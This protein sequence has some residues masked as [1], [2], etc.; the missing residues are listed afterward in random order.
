LDLADVS[1]AGPGTAALENGDLVGSK[2]L[3]NEKAGLLGMAGRSAE[4]VGLG[5]AC[6]GAAAA[7]STWLINM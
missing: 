4:E 6:D 1:G 7:A 3:Y 2:G 5:L